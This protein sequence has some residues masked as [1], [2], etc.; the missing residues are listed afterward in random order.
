[1]TGGIAMSARQV[2]WVVQRVGKGAQAW[3]EREARPGSCDAPVL[4]VSGDGT[5]VPMVAEEL[6]GRRGKQAMTTGSTPVSARPAET[7]SR[8][9]M[10]SG[11]LRECGRD[12]G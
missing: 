8:R 1:V 12:R 7:P 5:G 10:G 6:K 3:Q 11:C 9:I 4:Y 2:Q